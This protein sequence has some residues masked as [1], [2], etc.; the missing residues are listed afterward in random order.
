MALHYDTYSEEGIDDRIKEYDR[1]SAD[2]P[3]AS[4][5]CLDRFRP[6]DN[7]SWSKDKARQYAVPE[8]QDFGAYVKRIGFKLD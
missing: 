8:R 5:R 2:Q 1:R 7:Y 6:S 3:Y 4:Q